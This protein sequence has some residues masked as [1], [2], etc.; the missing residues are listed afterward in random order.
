M[1]FDIVSP[2]SGRA[3]RIDKVREYA[4]IPSI[5]RYVMLESASAAL[6]VLERT[7]RDKIWRS[8]VL[9]AGDV[10][11]IVPEDNVEVPVSDLGSCPDLVD[12]RWLG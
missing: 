5:Q 12:D 10:L 7:S 11:V 2:E 1:I 4:A 6:T 9:T 8:T 3:D